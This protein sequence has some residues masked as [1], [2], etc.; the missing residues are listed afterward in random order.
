MN[1]RIVSIIALFVIIV[2]ILTPI[3]P[4]VS[5]SSIESKVHPLLLKKLAEYKGS[6]VVEVVVRLKP[7]PHDLALS[8]RGSYY[9]AVNALKG[10]AE[11]TQAPVVRFIESLGGV[12][13]N[14]FWLDN[15]ILVRIPAKLVLK[16]AAHPDVVK[17][18]E[19]FEVRVIE[20]VYRET[21]YTKTMQVSSWGIFKI[22]ANETWALGVTGQGIR[23]AVLDTGVD[24]THPAL[25]GKMLSV[26]PGDPYYPG[27]WMEFDSSG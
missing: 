17:I 25:T 6:E 26:I 20:P 4:I 19:N 8:V 27:G 23:I 10:W 18:F 1:S 11:Y 9:A 7:L 24:I 3:L 5:A 15:V 22:R 12:V 21:T 2:S 14:R 16:I 13:V